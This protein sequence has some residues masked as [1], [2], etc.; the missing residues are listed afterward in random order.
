M[1]QR[2]S[3]SSAVGSAVRAM[4]GTPTRGYAEEG[5]VMKGRETSGNQTPREMDELLELSELKLRNEAERGKMLLE[6]YE[7]A[8]HLSEKQLYDYALD[9]AVKLTGSTIGFFHLI[10]DDQRE[11]V[12]TTWNSEALKNC[13]ASY[14]THYP[15]E[16]A[17]NWVDCVRFKQPVYYN[18]FARSPNQKGLPE[19]H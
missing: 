6:L 12:L 14:D 3:Q 1:V 10:S 5:T 13:V 11:I 15:I 16:Q 19:G 8:P 2:V 17:G 9:C 18:E 4:A 7:Q